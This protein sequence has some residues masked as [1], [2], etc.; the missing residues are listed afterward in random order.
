[1]QQVIYADVLIFLNTV[2]TFL[3]LLTVKQFTGASAGAGRLLIASFAGGVYSLIILAPKMNIF[4]M[5]AAKAAMCVSIVF[6]AFKAGSI[7]KMAKSALLFLAF[8]FLYAG[9][10]YSLSCLFDTSFF[11]V[12][13]GSVY[14]DLSVYSLII[15]SAVIYAVIRVL[16]KRFFT[17][18]PEDMI[19]SADIFY[20]GSSVKVNALLDSGNS[21][22]DIYTGK[23]VIILSAERAKCLTGVNLP[24]VPGEGDI[25]IRLLPVNALS[26]KKLLPA[27]TAD[28]AVIFC[29]SISREVKGPCV[30]V[31]D[32]ELGGEKY[33]AL[34]SGDFF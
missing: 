16:R 34:I 32:N 25:P 9:I 14:F 33:Q 20:R 8:S 28:S 4:L 30:A 31:T 15:I 27:F 13:N 6:I 24:D 22:K 10:M 18:S 23:P 12:N 29:D 7:R 3:L 19:Y 21:V 17:P 1:M 11:S 26:S 5:L 2:I